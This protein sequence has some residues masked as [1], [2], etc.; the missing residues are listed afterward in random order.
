MLDGDQTSFGASE[1]Q[2]RDVLYMTA[3]SDLAVATPGAL[4]TGNNC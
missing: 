4:S 3:R 1:K 2:V